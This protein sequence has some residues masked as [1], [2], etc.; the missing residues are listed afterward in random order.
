MFSPMPSIVVLCHYGQN[1]W[2]AQEHYFFTG[3][4]ERPDSPLNGFLESLF[5]LYLV[6]FFLNWT[7][8]CEGQMGDDEKGT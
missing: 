5:L 2:G 6:C 8:P 7:H 4:T 3:K 1:V